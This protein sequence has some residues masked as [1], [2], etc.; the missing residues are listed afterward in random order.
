MMRRRIIRGAAALCL[1]ASFLFAA[2]CGNKEKTEAPPQDAYG[3]V[4]ME[5]LVKAHPRYAEYFRLESEYKGL[6][7]QYQTEQKGLMR[8]AEALQREEASFS[9]PAADKA[10]EEEYKARVKIKEDSLNQQL[11][12]L[13]N[14]IEGRHRAEKSQLSMAGV[15]DDE[16][17]RIANLQLKLKVL[18]ISGEEKAKA[19]EELQALLNGRYAVDGKTGWTAEE[20]QEMEAKK[21]SAEAELE[22]YAQQVAADIRSKRDSQMAALAS[23]KLPEPELWNQE[24]EGRLKAKQKEMAD[25]KADIMKDIRDKAAVIGEEKH[26]TMIFSSYR[27][28]VSAVDVTGDIVGELVQLKKKP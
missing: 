18:G 7:A 9:S 8:Q 19:E 26:L 1:A 28:N 11:Q 27:T 10:A 6:L 13:Y 4:D 23:A 12:N 24:W 25:V 2:G 3:I 20:K 15:S 17:T 14:E 22:Q 5:T 16:S 21:K